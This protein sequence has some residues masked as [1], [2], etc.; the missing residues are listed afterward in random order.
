MERA[1]AINSKTGFSKTAR[2]DLQDALDTLSEDG[3][4]VT[5]EEITEAIQTKLDRCSA[6]DP[7]SYVIFG[8]SLAA[9][10]VASVRVKRQRN[11][12]AA[13]AAEDA[14]MW[15]Q[16]QAQ[17]RAVRDDVTIDLEK[18]TDGIEHFDFP[19]MYEAEADALVE[20]AKAYRKNLDPSG[21][22]WREDYEAIWM[23]LSIDLDKWIEDHPPVGGARHYS[24]DFGGRC[25]R[26]EKIRR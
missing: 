15:K 24:N 20:E 16:W 8:S 10:L 6:S 4:G 3:R 18:W 17:L 22:Q 23:D 13:L 2:G 25:S 9:D 26:D 19:D 12:K 21:E 14:R 7:T 1:K 11:L 5:K